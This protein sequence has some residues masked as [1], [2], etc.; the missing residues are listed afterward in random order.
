MDG[1]IAG[2]WSVNGTGGGTE[3]VVEPFTTLPAAVARRAE[4]EAERLTAILAHRS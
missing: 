1:A 2:T 3:I 4:S